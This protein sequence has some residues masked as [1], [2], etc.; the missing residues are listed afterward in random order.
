[1]AKVFCLDD[2]PSALAHLTELVQSFRHDAVAAATVDE[3]WTALHESGPFDLLILDN[4]LGEG[5]GYDLLE[6]LRADSIYQHIPVVIYTGVSDR[7]SVLTYIGLKIQNILVKPYK[8][9]RLEVEIQKAMGSDWIEKAVRGHHGSGMGSL[10]RD[11]YDALLE[12]SSTFLER[13]LSL[14]QQPGPPDPETWEIEELNDVM[15]G[16]AQLGFC[17]LEECLGEVE[18]FCRLHNWEEVQGMSTRLRFLL[19]T[20]D[21]YRVQRCELVSR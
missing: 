21:N 18:T 17:A 5:H 16:A 10:S 9:E 7:K 8:A 13:L 2:D 4:D 3:A 1:M 19:R 14:L 20:L 11:E 6:R 12:S 15:V